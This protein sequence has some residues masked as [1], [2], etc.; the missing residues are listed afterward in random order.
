MIQFSKIICLV[1]LLVNTHLAQAQSTDASA[2]GTVLNNQ[3]KPLAGATVTIINNSTGFKLSAQT[4]EKGVYSFKQLPLGSP[5]SIQVSFVGLITQVKNN[6]SLNLGDQLEND[7]VLLDNNTSLSEVV[8][9]S[10]SISSRIDR[11]GAST[12]ISARTI[13]QIPAQN[14]NFNDLASLSPISNGANLG[15]QRFSSTNY[16]I[17]GV[18][19]RNNLTSGEIGRGRSPYHLKLL[20]N[21]K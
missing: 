20:E 12:A 17:D 15:G 8:V 6:L 9:T 13:Q 1:V 11:F 7:F 16:L 3:Q 4:N 19:A 21:L 18:S 5:Y 14:R 10:N 2:T